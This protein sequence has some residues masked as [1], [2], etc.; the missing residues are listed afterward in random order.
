M[1]SSLSSLKR[2]LDDDNN[3]NNKSVPSGSERMSLAD[4]AAENAAADA[5]LL[6]LF[7][8]ERLTRKHTHDSCCSYERG[9]IDQRVFVCIHCVRKNAA[10]APFGVC[11][12]CFDVCH[13]ACGALNNDPAHV[14]RDNVDF[15]ALERKRHFRCDC[16][17][18]AAPPDSPC[19]WKLPTKFQ[20]RWSVPEDQIA[21]TRAAAQ[22]VRATRCASNQYGQN[23]RGLYCWCSKPWSFD[24]DEVVSMIQCQA[25]LEWYHDL[26]CLLPADNRY[27]GAPPHAL[28]CRSCVPKYAVLHPYL[29][30]ATD[31]R[32]P[33]A[34]ASSDD[35]DDDGDGDDGDDDPEL[36]AA[37][38]ASMGGDAANASTVAVQC[39]RPPPLASGELRVDVNLFADFSAVLCNCAECDAALHA[40]GIHFLVEEQ[41]TDDVVEDVVVPEDLP[42]T[43]VFDTATDGLSL[44][45][46]H[47]ASTM[48]SDF[49][50][51]LGAMLANKEHGAEVTAADVEQFKRNMDAAL[52]ARRQNQ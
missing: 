41:V 28:V 48:L 9:A 42:L 1:S 39:R 23:F 21:A 51:A 49:R 33:N 46:R 44:Q 16:G 5:Q 24:T 3:N 20:G 45:Q 47:V 13:R 34:D 50:A 17:T 43:D 29:A 25:C 32:P 27:V 12:A 11:A 22:L 18:A 8:A 38:V 7:D 14:A 19:L 2:K 31:V 6:S 37:L 36:Q 30:A 26:R 4:I 15:Y 52:A 35:D 40:A 10:A